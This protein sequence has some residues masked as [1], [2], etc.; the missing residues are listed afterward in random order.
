MN[1]DLCKGHG[2]ILVRERYNDGDETIEARTCHKCLGSGQK[3]DEQ[4][5]DDFDIAG[6]SY[7]ED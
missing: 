4:E 7:E 2:T 6:S 3:H 1:C 5:G